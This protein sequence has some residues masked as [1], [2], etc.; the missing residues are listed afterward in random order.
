MDTLPPEFRTIRLQLAREP[1]HPQG[2]RKT[3]YEL[4]APLDSANRLS[5]E[6]WRKHRDHCRVRRFHEGE[7]DR[8]G[9]LAR[10]P[11][12]SWYFDYDSARQSDN[13]AGYRLGN[14]RFTPG[15]YVSIA[16]DHGRMHTYQVVSVQP[17]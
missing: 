1:Q 16:D 11:G 13:E 14:E 17:V 6:L 9:R 12:G 15:E 2:S 4:I 5:A 8:L 3:G 7:E 10:H